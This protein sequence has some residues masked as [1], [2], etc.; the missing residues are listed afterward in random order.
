MFKYILFTLI[1]FIIFLIFINKYYEFVINYLLIPINKQNEIEIKNYNLYKEIPNLFFLKE[2]KLNLFPIFEINFDIKEITIIIYYLVIIY[3][4]TYLIPILLLQL[5]LFTKSSFFSHEKK[6]YTFII[7]F[8][9]MI[10][11][12]NFYINNKVYMSYILYILFNSYQQIN[13][14]IFDLNFNLYQYLS[15]YLL[16]LIINNLWILFLVINLFYSLNSKKLICFII[17][18]VIAITPPNILIYFVELLYLVTS[19]LIIKFIF[20]IKYYIKRIPSEYK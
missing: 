4:I 1:H 17:L 15:F 5:L 6:K 13:L 20:I 14:Y 16:I 12:F 11:F 3:I 10:L 7:I 18:L 9:L 8:F 19:Y 2:D